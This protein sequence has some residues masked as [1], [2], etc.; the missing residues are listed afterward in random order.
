MW[1]KVALLLSGIL[2]AP[3]FARTQRPE[4]PY[5]TMLRRVGGSAASLG[6]ATAALDAL[7]KVALG[8]IWDI[9]PE[10]A[11][12]FGLP[13][14]ELFQNSFS[15]M[16]VRTC[17]L[18]EIARIDSPQALAFLTT[19]RQADFLQDNSRQMWTSVQYA[20]AYA[21]LKRIEDPRK[22]I[23]FLEG[24]VTENALTADWAVQELCDRGS[25]GSKAIIVRA[26][27]ARQNGRFDEEEIRFCD[28]RILVMEGDPDPVRALGS[29]LRVDR[30]WSDDRLIGWAVGQLRELRS[31][32][33]YRE[34]ELRAAEM[35]KLPRNA[36]DKLRWENI[37]R[38]ISEFLATIKE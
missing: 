1:C 27:R 37:R 12:Q 32:A 16:E 6:R 30:G 36:P 10:T 22:Q 14:G 29:V 3:C 31:P 4:E 34:L 38:A 5:C 8:R 2:V 17:A 24:I 26:I 13:S 7:A 35:S 9:A 21:R 19:V 25:G 33:A 28:A 18:Y 11:A 23:E 20:L 15:M